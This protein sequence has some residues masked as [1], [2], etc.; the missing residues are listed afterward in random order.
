LATKRSI[1][2]STSALESIRGLPTWTAWNVG[3]RA[4]R[5]DLRDELEGLV[6]KWKRGRYQSDGFTTSWLKIRN[7]QYSHEAWLRQPP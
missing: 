4:A 1:D 7:Q 6:A 5:T 2:G 3:D